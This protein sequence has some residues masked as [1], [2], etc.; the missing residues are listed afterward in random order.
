MTRKFY[1]KEEQ[2]EKGY[3]QAPTFKKREGWDR[4]QKEVLMGW[5]N[6]F[7]E[8]NQIQ[9]CKK[10]YEPSREKKKG[11]LKNKEMK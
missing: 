11:I 9:K 2:I 5:K 4:K 6:Y 7:Q 8:G 1:C 3:H 10:E